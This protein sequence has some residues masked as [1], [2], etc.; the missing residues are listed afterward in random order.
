MTAVVKLF[1][2]G[3]LVALPVSPGSSQYRTDSVQ[4]LSYPYLVAEAFAAVGAV[5]QSNSAAAT[6]P[7][8]TKVLRIEVQVGKTVAFEVTPAN[9]TLRTVAAASSPTLEGRNTIPFGAGDR[10]S[11]L[12]V[13]A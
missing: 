4:S 7:V 10:I 13:T 1:S 6:A 8:G 3:E 2:H 11:L 12:D 9:H 5:S